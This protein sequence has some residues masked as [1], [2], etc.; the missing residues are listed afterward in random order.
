[1]EGFKSDTIDWGAQVN[2]GQKV[3]ERTRNGK[4]VLTI[5][6][7]GFRAEVEGKLVKKPP[8]EASQQYS[9]ATEYYFEGPWKVLSVTLLKQ[10]RFEMV[11]V[12]ADIMA[13]IEKKAPSEKSKVVPLRSRR[14]A[15]GAR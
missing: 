8:P 6:V 12:P 15:G 10:A 4:T 5:E 2:P 1:M 11:I 9:R 3:G 13:E 14:R 7:K